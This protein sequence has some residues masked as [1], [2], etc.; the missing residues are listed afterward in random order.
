MEYL[1]EILKAI[2]ALLWPVMVILVLFWFRKDVRGV[3][4]SARSRKFSVKVGEMELS[5]DE[6][7]KQQNDLIRDL[8]TQVAAM[9]KSLEDGK[10]KKKKPATAGESAPSTRS[11]LWV[12][13]HPK[14]NAVLIQNLTESEIRVT[15]AATNEEALSLIRA[16]KFDKIVTD[17]RHPKN[18]SVIDTAGLDLVKVIREMDI[19]I[20]VYIYTSPSKVEELIDA[21]QEADA[22]QITGS[23]TILLALLKD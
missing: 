23:A 15:T 7:S 13:D 10:A 1:S 6:Y 9:Q 5:M 8:Q 16:M 4:D 22:N 3:I 19:H 11:I 17:L 14:N 21:A 12:D 18:G 2:A 20:P